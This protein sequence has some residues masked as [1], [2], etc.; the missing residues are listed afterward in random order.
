[1]TNPRKQLT[2]QMRVTIGE[3]LHIIRRRK[4]LSLAQLRDLT[5]GDLSESQL[6]ALENDEWDTVELGAVIDAFAALDRELMIG[7]SPLEEE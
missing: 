6:Y 2:G 5:F 4:G 1:M 7:M 3:A